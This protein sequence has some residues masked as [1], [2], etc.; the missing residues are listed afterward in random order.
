VRIHKTAPPFIAR[1]LP[2]VSLA[3]YLLLL[4][5][6]T[7]RDINVGEFYF[8]TDEENHAVTGLYFKDF[9]RAMPLRNAVSFTYNYYAHYPALGI[10][11]WPPLFYVVE[12][13]VFLVAGPSV[14]SARFTILLFM[15]LSLLFFFAL[16]NYLTNRLTAIIGMA[17]LA[18]M[19]AMVLFEKLVMLE[20]PAMAF[21]IACGYYLVRHARENRN[22]DAYL[23]ALMMALAL[24]TKQNA[25]FLPVF[26]VFYLLAQRKWHLILSPVGAKAACMVAFIAGPYYAFMAWVYGKTIAMALGE[27]KVSISRGALAYLAA[28]PSQTSWILLACALGGLVVVLLRRQREVFAF[29][30]SWITACWLVMALI[31]HKENRY[32]MYWLPGFALLAATLFGTEMAH[33]LRRP[34]IAAASLVLIAVSAKA[35][36]FERPYI[37]GYQEVAKQLV[38]RTH[39]GVVLVDDLDGYGTLIFF[40]NVMDP[41]RKLYF[42]RKALY[43][44]RWNKDF[45][46]TNL[47]SRPDD[48]NRIVNDYGIN[49]IVVAE[50]SRLEYEGQS[51]LQ[52]YLR[53]GRFKP[54]SR[55]QIR[56]NLSQWKNRAVILY[57][58]QSPIS[59]ASKFLNI[60]ILSLGREIVV[61]ISVLK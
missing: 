53:L 55:I 37:C 39:Q 57:Q 32:V 61:P 60:K 30:I 13:A 12:G 26:A 48:V 17:F 18:F 43:A 50:N 4:V 51:V 28:I 33:K 5:A 14:I 2:R 29:S 42:V 35:I 27:K 1:A 15:A 34:Q 59:P 54:V 10:V 23:C 46:Y 22:R 16:V 24:L 40:G 52:D 8:N 45:G 11:H 36:A 9:Y 44:V 41:Q 25:V 21:C 56:T 20:I 7:A 58:N 38:Q 31:G 47:V 6:I 19:P 3:V 49:Y